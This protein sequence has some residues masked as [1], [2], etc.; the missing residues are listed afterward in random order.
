[1]KVTKLRGFFENWNKVNTKEELIELLKGYKGVLKDSMVN[2]LNSLIELEFSVVREYIDND[3]RKALSELELYK[4]IAIYNIYNR[5]LNLFNQQNSEF[6]ISGNNDGLESL[7]ISTKLNDR[8][9]QL[10]CFDYDEH[11]SCDAKV[12]SCYKTM[13]IGNISLYQTLEI[14]SELREA[15]LN[16]VMNKLEELY[17]QKDPFPLSSSGIYGSPSSQWTY[18]HMQEINEYEKIFE[19]LDNKKEL[20]DDDKREIEITNQAHSMLLEDYGLKNES[21]EEK[22]NKFLPNS[23]KIVLKKT[24]IK[25]QPNL[26]ISNNINYM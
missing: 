5:A 24:L 1:M 21:F 2:Y 13:K 16:R 19:Q 4:R 22:E 18:R 9:V 15:Q 17:N 14:S 20:S 10:F 3:D 6:I 12:P 11:I 8:T 25:K 26:T 23:E 7:S